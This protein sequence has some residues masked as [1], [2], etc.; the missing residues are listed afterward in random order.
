MAK[1]IIPMAGYCLV[2]DQV[3]DKLASGLALADDKDKATTH[4]GEV[5][6]IGSYPFDLSTLH[7]NFGTEASVN[8]HIA[9]YYSEELSKGDMIV[10][11]R[12]SGNEVDLEGVEYKL[13]GFQDITAILK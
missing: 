12:Y 10:Y 13:V 7:E 5:I 11:K 2:E 6:A 1:K 9:F 3:E 4:I 8:E